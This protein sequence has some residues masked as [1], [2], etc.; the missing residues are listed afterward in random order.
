MAPAVTIGPGTIGALFATMLLLAAL[1]GVA[2]LMVAA[3]IAAYGF[4]HGALVTRGLVTRDAVLVTAVHS[5]LALAAQAAAGWCG[6]VQLASGAWLA[7]PGI[8]Q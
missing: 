1:P 5:G 7:V 4:R 3:R 8:R 2:S 6:A